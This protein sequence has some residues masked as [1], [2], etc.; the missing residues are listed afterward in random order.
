L[1][2]Y[3]IL[4]SAAKRLNA[5]IAILTLTLAITQELVFRRDSVHIF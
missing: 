5:L 2:A 1:S 4:H 3:G